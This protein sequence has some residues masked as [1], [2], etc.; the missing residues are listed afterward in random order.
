M[1][2]PLDNEAPE[3]GA[4]ELQFAG[5]LS[6]YDQISHR[7]GPVTGLIFLLRKKKDAVRAEDYEAA[8]FLRDLII[9]H[10]VKELI[11]SS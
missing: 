11:A 2:T 5:L 3:V 8:A 4:R 1:H 7:Q 9:D 6:I 10:K